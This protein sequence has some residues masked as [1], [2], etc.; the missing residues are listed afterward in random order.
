MIM[1]QQMSFDGLAPQATDR[2][3]FGVFPDPGTAGQIW[4]SAQTLRSKHGVSGKPVR[5]DRLHVTLH[6]LGDYD[7]VPRDIVVKASKAAE[8]VSAYRSTS[9][10]TA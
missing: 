10:S 6:H 9:R 8:S 2:L 5:K 3:F 1:S 7:G 4:E